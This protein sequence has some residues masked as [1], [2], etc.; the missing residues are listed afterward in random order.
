M[1]ETKLFISHA[2]KDKILIDKFVDLLDTGCG[3]P[4]AEIFCT[5]LED[6]GV[7]PGMDFIQ[8]IKSTIQNP[9]FV[10]LMLSPNY[11]NSVFC[12]CE[13]GASWALS[14]SIFPIVIPPLKKSD[15][16]D[17]LAV[18][19]LGE[20]TD[21]SCLDNLRDEVITAHAI[22]DSPTATWSVKRDQFL[23]DLPDILRELPK[24]E[25][26]ST[27]DYYDL[28]AKY[29][30]S[31]KQLSNM[32]KE[33]KRSQQIIEELKKCKDARQVSKII[34][35][36]SDKWKVFDGLTKL[37][38]EKMS[39][40]DN[41]A[42]EAIYYHFKGETLILDPWQDRDR[43]R[44]AKEA[45]DEGFLIY[46]DEEGFSPNERDPIVYEALEGI[47]NLDEFLSSPDNDTF[48]LEFKEKYGYE[49]SLNNKRFWHYHISKI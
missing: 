26:V 18:T 42:C 23:N 12:L 1:G 35:S 3:L 6:L 46:Y 39:K 27:K 15:I 32:N 7:P 4:R 30:K 48:L 21:S 8:F 17:I 2:S 11:Y 5:S 31:L 36:Y 29:Q 25:R 20:L 16:Q 24:P 19:Q 40:L 37:A 14:L 47:R 38:K 9:S 45:V 13:L 44:D 28:K 10:V 33:I 43:V 34:T 49:A 22:E 41:V